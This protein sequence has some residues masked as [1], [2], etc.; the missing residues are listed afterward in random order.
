MTLNSKPSFEPV[1]VNL[2]DDADYAVLAEAL[3]DYAGAR[4]HQAGQE[5]ES[6]LYNNHADPKGAGA[7]WIKGA[8]RAGALFEGPE[9]Q[10]DANSAARRSSQL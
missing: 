6:A 4:R 1:L 10:L 3:R 2:S 9:R 8:E 7:V 5:I